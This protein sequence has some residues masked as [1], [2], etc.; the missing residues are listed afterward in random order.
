MITK[1]TTRY[2]ATKKIATDLQS[3]KMISKY[4]LVFFVF[5]AYNALLSERNY[6][7]DEEDLAQY[8]V[9]NAFNRIAYLHLKSSIHFV[10]NTTA[11]DNTSNKVFKLQPLFEKVNKHFLKFGFF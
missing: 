8:I 4:S 5:S 9:K 2:A 11:K 10:D 3:L 1:E 6:W 7:S